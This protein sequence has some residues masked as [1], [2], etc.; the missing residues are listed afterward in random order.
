MKGKD[1]LKNHFDSRSEY[2]KE[3]LTIYENIGTDIYPLLVKAEKEGKKLSVDESKLP[4][5]WDTFGVNHIIMV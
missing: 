1:I 3:L 5:L 4:K 2:A